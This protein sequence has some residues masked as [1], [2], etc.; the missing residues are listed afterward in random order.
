MTVKQPVA[1]LGGGSF[2]TALANLIAANGYPVRL[3]MRDSAQAASIRETGKN[4][5]YL[6]DISLLSGIEANTDLAGTLAVCELVFVALPSMA[7]RA[8]LAPQRALCSG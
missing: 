3:W 1:V 6:K 5:R 7:L 2:G 8:V 4:P